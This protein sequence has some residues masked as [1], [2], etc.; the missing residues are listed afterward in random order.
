MA[1][2]S[3]FQTCEFK[4]E[5]SHLGWFL[6]NELSNFVSSINYI[7][8]SSIKKGFLIRNSKWEFNCTEL[9]PSSNSFI[10]T[11]LHHHMHTIQT[12]FLLSHKKSE[13][14]AILTQEMINRIFYV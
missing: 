2:V 1:K 6:K 8:L 14:D 9:S 5:I 10:K 13:R 7:Y 11:L 12:A 3:A 4:T